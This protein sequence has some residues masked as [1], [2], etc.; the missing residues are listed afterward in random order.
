MFS[1][2]CL[3]NFGLGSTSFA[4][5]LTWAVV[6]YLCELCVVLNLFEVGYKFVHFV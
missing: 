3:F 2:I 5:V 4:L 1:V 6:L